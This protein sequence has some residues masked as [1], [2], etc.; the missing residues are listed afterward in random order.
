LIYATKKFALSDISFKIDLPPSHGQYDPFG[1]ID[2]VKRPPEGVSVLGAVAALYQIAKSFAPQKDEIE[3]D[4]SIQ[5]KQRI[6]TTFLK[7][8]VAGDLWQWKA[9][10]S[11]KSR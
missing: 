9:L 2:D 5:K 3:K 1:L 4:T 8:G 7:T 6:E 10:I 11:L